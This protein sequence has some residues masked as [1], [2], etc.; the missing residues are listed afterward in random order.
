MRADRIADLMCKV[1]ALEERGAPGERENARRMLDRLQRIHG[2]TEA[3]L[4]HVRVE[5]DHYFRFHDDTEKQLL[6]QVIYMVTGRIAGRAIRK[7][8]GRRIKELG[9]NCTET[10]KLE[11][12][13][14]FEFYL[15]ALKEELDL[16]MTA[17]CS[18]NNLFPDDPKEKVPNREPDE[19]RTRRVMA[20][21]QGMEHR[22]NLK[23]LE[24]GT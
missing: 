8:S 15:R 3:E 20:M 19:D 16:F 9:V 12:E 11:I 21:M 18:R 4:E 23:R 14:A 13:T 2:V 7:W 24:D 5:S 10:E 22:R 17:F 1:K 6:T